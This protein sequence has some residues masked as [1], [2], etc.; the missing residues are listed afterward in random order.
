MKQKK[1]SVTVGIP[2]YNEEKNIIH[3][4]KDVLSQN[5]NLW[6]LKEI[7]VVDDYSS[8]STVKKIKRFGSIKVK[9]I[10]KKFRRGKSL[11]LN[12]IF[13][14]FKSDVLVLFDGDVRLK[15]NFTIERLVAGFVNNK[16]LMLTSGDK[17]PF[18]PKTFIQR[19]IFSTYKVFH[20]SK[21][22][23]NG[24]NNIFGCQGGCIAMRSKFAKEII[25][26]ATLAEDAYLYLLC[27][28]KGYEFRYI[29]DAAVF[30]KLANNT[31]EYSSQLVRATPK[32]ESITLDE[33]SVS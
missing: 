33:F 18:K 6:S 16:N 15:S 2:A 24:G 13:T 4:L 22:E 29:D 25:L 32:S 28:K 5:K 1:I 30:Y 8:D 9:V 21:L 31:I 11:C 3:L 17:I 12:D 14:E 20:K 19:G 7:I 26:P 23:I 10:G 27:M